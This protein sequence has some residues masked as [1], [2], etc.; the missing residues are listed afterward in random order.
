MLS[1]LSGVVD[2]I[3]TRDQFSCV[4]MSASWLIQSSMDITHDIIGISIRNVSS[5]GDVLCNWHH[6]VEACT[7]WLDEPVSTAHATPTIRL[8]HRSTVAVQSHD[9]IVICTKYIYKQ[10]KLR[11]LIALQKIDVSRDDDDVVLSNDLLM[12]KCRSG[13][14]RD[15]LC[16]ALISLCRTGVNLP[17][18][19]HALSWLR[20]KFL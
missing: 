12:S 20:H 14:E 6:M 16:D 17:V 5:N 7:G 11:M 8:R 10:S 1:V 19:R 9:K 18:A 2:R 13:W 4:I 3:Q 15:W